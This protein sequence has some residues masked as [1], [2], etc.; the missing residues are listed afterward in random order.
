M[1]IYDVIN[2]TMWHIMTSLELSKMACIVLTF[3]KLT[4]LRRKTFQNLM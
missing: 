1:A 4:I 2:L 3:E